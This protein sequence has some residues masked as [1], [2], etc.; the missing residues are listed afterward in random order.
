M[1]L[2]FFRSCLSSAHKLTAIG[3]R[4]EKYFEQTRKKKKQVSFCKV[5]QEIWPKLYIFCIPPPPA[6]LYLFLLLASSVQSENATSGRTDPPSGSWAAPWERPAADLEEDRPVMII[7]A[8]GK[9]GQ[10]NEKKESKKT[11]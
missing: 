11:I 10:E 3:G 7:K 8:A 9:D 5:R 6:P 1:L 4:R 2:T